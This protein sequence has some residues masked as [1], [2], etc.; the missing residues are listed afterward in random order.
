MIPIV[1]AAQMRAVEAA[2]FAR[3]VSE[4]ELGD[5]A[6]LAIRDRVTALTPPGGRVLVLAG[7][8]NN[9]LDGV[10]VHGLLRDGG[11]ESTLVCWNRSDCA[12]AL[13]P[14]ALAA[15]LDRA[16]LVLDALFGIGLTRDVEGEAAWL[17]GAVNAARARRAETGEPLMVVALDVPSGLNADSGAAM[18]TRS[19][20]ASSAG[21]R[22]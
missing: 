14:G 4:D 3:G 7:P 8:G 19:V 15:E 16:A 10:K 20:R 13:D 6:A 12:D 21:S 18:G 22:P 5:R 2:E 9:G 11:I 17:V 1:T